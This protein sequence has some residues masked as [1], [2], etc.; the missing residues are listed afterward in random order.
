[1]RV[2]SPG[3]VP[4]LT[5]WGVSVDADLVYRA[6]AIV[7]SMGETLLVREL[8]VTPTVAVG[9]RLRHYEPDEPT[10]VQAAF[11]TVPTRSPVGVCLMRSAN[12]RLACIRL[13][14]AADAE[15]IA[16]PLPTDDPL[17]DR[18]VQYVDDALHPEPGTGFCATCLNLPT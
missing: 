4:S 10:V 7:G 16:T 15:M 14:I 18:P 2:T 1:M 8:G 12:V 9:S 3:A 5:R 13:D 17:V 6:L 11:G